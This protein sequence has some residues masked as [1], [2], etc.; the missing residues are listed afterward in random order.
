[1]TPAGNYTQ[2]YQE[3]QAAI[4]EFHQA[5]QLGHQHGWAYEAG[6]LQ[7]ALARVIMAL[8]RRQR[9]EELAV[10]RQQAREI[11]AV[12]VVSTLVNKE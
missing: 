3:T 8:P 9:E 6:W 1:M 7:S 2:R 11:E 4:N 10:L 5:C 12:H